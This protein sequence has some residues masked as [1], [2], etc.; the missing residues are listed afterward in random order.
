MKK[1]LLTS[2]GLLLALSGCATVNES[3]APFPTKDELISFNDQWAVATKAGNRSVFDLQRELGKYRDRIYQQALERSKL[4]WES[5]GATTYGGLAAVIGG[6]ADQTGLMNSGAGLAALGLTN[7]TRY[8]FSE[9]TQIYVTALKKLSCIQGK[10]NAMD[11][12]TLSL[13]KR[14]SDPAAQSAA[15]HFIDKVITSVDAVRA[16]YTNAL[17]GMAPVVSSNDELKAIARQY[18]QTTVAVAATDDPEQKMYDKAGE[19]AI[20]LVVGIQSCT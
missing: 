12:L 17:L 18:L 15:N 14:S 8:R 7:S 1:H 16:E 13:A 6:L 5:T 11:D 4:N 9:Q 2:L 10:V 19:T 3:W 20:E